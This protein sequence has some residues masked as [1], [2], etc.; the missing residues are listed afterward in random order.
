MNN[1]CIRN[2]ICIS[3]VLILVVLSC[4]ISAAEVKW[5]NKSIGLAGYEFTSLCIDKNNPD[6]IYAGSNGALLKTIDGGDTWKNIF[7]K[8][9]RGVR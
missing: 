1:M 2:K 9:Q 6:I 5:I 3:V 8:L 4:E 7:I